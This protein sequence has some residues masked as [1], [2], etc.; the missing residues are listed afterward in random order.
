MA[1]IAN[2]DDTLS[3]VLQIFIIKKFFFSFVEVFYLIEI[4]L[5]VHIKIIY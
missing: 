3:F 5:N 1:V 4:H 2:I